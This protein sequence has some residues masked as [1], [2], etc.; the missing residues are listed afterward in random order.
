M[1]GLKRVAWPPPADAV[2]YE[3]HPSQQKQAVGQQFAPQQQQFYQ[4][5][6]PQ[7]QQQQQQQQPHP[8][9]QPANAHQQQP[10]QRPVE[11]IVPIQR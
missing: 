8:T 6:I 9:Y 7:Q 11:R 10:G 3:P 2:E 5:T 4:Q 1:E